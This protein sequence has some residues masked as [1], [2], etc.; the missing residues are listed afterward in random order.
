MLILSEQVLE[1]DFTRVIVGDKY[2]VTL[3]RPDDWARR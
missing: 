2:R 1:I 3:N